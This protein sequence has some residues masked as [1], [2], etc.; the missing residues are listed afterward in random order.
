VIPQD[1]VIFNGNL[2][3]NIDPKHEVSDEKLYD[4]I[5][6]VGLK[7]LLAH[8]KHDEVDQESADEEDRC[9]EGLNR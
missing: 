9:G 1:P 7:D 3:F 8:E 5:E 6:Q 2:R 4:L